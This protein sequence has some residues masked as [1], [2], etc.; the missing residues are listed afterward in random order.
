ME[1]LFSFIMLISTSA[2]AKEK[3]VE[4]VKISSHDEFHKLVNTGMK[5]GVD[6]QIQTYLS[7]NGTG[8]IGGARMFEGYGKEGS[9][10]QFD[11]KIRFTHDFESGSDE[12]KRLYDVRNKMGCFIVY[13]ATNQLWL[14][15]FKEGSCE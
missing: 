3:K 14:K 6:Y 8:F 5:V 7:K 12:I 10:N 4:F 2:I 9:L 13:M 15:S 11:R 1:Y